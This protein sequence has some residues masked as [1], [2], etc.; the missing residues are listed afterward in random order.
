MHSIFLC[1]NQQMSMCDSK[2]FLGIV[3]DVR[4]VM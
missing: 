4:G 2:E 1:E 3:W